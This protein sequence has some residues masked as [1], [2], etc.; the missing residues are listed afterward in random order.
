MLSVRV[1]VMI[2]GRAVPIEELADA[3]LAGALRNAGQDVAQRLGGIRCPVHQK[4]ATNVRVHF[5]ARG[6]ADLQYESCCETLGS[7][8]GKALG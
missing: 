1:T 6:N 7:R 5:D 4:T 2:A 8:I 3:R